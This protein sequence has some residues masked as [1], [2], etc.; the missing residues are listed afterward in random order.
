MQKLGEHLGT[1]MIPID[2]LVP[3][4]LNANTMP[5]DLME[6]LRTHIK[7][8]RRYPFIVVR[9]HPKD[10]G[11]FE[12]LDGHHRVLAAKRSGTDI[13]QDAIYWTDKPGSLPVAEKVDVYSGSKPR[14]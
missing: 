7:R 9:P 8:T 13:P 6:K 11:Q 14:S 4:P 3:H 5:D 10:T 12:I 1:R 2:N